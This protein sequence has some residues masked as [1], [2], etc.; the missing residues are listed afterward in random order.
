MDE[1]GKKFAIRVENA[2]GKGEN[3]VGKGENVRCK[4]FLLFP[5]CFLPVWKTFCH[6]HQNLKLLSATPFSLEV[7]TVC[8]LGNAIT[9]FT[10]GP[11][12]KVFPDKKLNLYHTTKF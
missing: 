12:F 6:F 10:C 1:K 4:Q 5:Q 11:K 2:V 9:K 7:S 3:A 8:H